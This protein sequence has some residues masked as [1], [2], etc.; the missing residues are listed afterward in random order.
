MGAHIFSASGS[1]TRM[2]ASSL[3]MNTR[4]SFSPTTMLRSF[5]RSF[6]AIS[7]PEKPRMMENGPVSNRLGNTLRRYVSRSASYGFMRSMVL[8]K[9]AAITEAVSSSVSP[10]R[11]SR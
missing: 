6:S 2:A 5:N 9:G 4:S 3:E 1:M 11:R 7:P 8:Q 10:C